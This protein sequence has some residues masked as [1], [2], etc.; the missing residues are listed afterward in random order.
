MR[1]IT[2]KNHRIDILEGLRGLA[3]LVVFLYHWL[4]GFFPQFSGLW[5][6]FPKEQAWLGRWGF[7]FINGSGAV[8]F[9]FVL[10][11]FVLSRRVLLTYATETIGE[12][13]LKRWPRLAF[14]TC[15]AC[16]ISWVFFATGAYYYPSAALI[17]H[18]PWLGGFAGAAGLPSQRLLTDAFMQGLWDTFFSGN[19]Y[20][21]SSMWTMHYEFIASFMIFGTCLL[22]VVYRNL[23]QWISVFP[24]LIITLLCSSVSPWYPPFFLGLLIAFLLPERLKVSK[25]TRIIL[26]SLGLYCLG[27]FNSDGL[28][29]HGYTIP[30]QYID[31]V[32]SIF[33]ISSC[34]DVQLKGWY[35]KSAQFLGQLS[36]PFYL[37]H[38]LF[39]CSFGSWLF[40]TLKTHHVVHPSFFSGVATLVVSILASLPFIKANTLW[41]KVLNNV[42][43]PLRKKMQS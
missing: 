14:P 27:Y 19:A 40:L 29:I 7:F 11:G 18:S 24:V 21:D 9:F 15:V 22:L 43:Q 6:D 20:Y 35:Q 1:Q 12:A 36:F 4:L 26:A 41:L 2:Q 33:V 34:Y 13:A 23:P 32:G 30:F 8:V 5:P 38:A 31:G 28:R 3:A 37:L 25:V 16:L 10:S 39:I 42:M 17:T